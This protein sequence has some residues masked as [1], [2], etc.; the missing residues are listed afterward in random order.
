MSNK[1]TQKIASVL[2][3]QNTDFLGVYLADSKSNFYLSLDM[4][5]GLRQVG[6]LSVLVPLLSLQVGTCK[7]GTITA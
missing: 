3:P 7:M 4:L 2:C 1:G 5:S 6:C